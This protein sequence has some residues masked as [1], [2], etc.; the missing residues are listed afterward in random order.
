MT[1]TGGDTPVMPVLERM[2]QKDHQAPRL[3]NK[4]LS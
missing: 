3:Q 4:I 1:I 2:R